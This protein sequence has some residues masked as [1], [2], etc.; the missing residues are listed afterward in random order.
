[1]DYVDLMQCHRFDATTPL[2]E[3]LRALDDLQASGKALYC[4]ISSW[5]A[6]QISEAHQLGKK[7]GFRPL[8]SNQP[9]YNLLNR[10]EEREVMAA[11]DLAG[12][13]WVIYSPLAQ[14]VLTG[15]YQSKKAPAGSR[16]ADGKRNQWI[17]PLLS[18][19]ILSRVA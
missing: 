2:L 11:S 3:T 18:P 6:G 10:G 17:K 19:A 1:M 8:I 13:G 15:K 4:G 5:S 7:H 12:M 16:A 9:L 14:G